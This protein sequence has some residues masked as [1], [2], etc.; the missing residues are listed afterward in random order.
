MKSF[1]QW[2]L[3]LLA[4]NTGCTDYTVS[5]LDL[6]CC[7]CT[8]AMPDL[9]PYTELKQLKLNCREDVNLSTLASQAP[10]LEFLNLK[11]TNVTDLTPLKSLH[12]LKHLNLM[13]TLVTDI[14][15]L[16]GLA[17][18][19]YLNINYAPISDLGPLAKLPK[20]RVDGR[21]MTSCMP[22][23]TSVCKPLMITNCPT[24]PDVASTGLKDYCVYAQNEGIAVKPKPPETT[25]ATQDDAK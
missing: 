11:G 24:D 8:D 10:Q 20:L 19:D 17:E 16:S 22:G 23:N 14:T 2:G 21:P 12:Q 25:P 9:S 7:D 3:V 5:Q 4:I 6:T 15:P 1:G 18:L 13:L